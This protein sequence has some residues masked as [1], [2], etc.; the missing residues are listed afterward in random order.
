[1]IADAAAVRFSGR[2]DPGAAVQVQWHNGSKSTT[3]GGNGNWN[4][5]FTGLE[6]PASAGGDFPYS[7][8]ATSA[9]GNTIVQPGQIRVDRQAPEAPVIAQVE[10][11]GTVTLGERANGVPVTGSGE[12]GTEVRILWGST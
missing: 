10:G 7:I 4:L 12:P 1:S 5:D 9:I 2:T 8:T 6:V 11:D 3:A